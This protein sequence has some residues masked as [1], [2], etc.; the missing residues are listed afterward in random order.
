MTRHETKR[1]K[2]DEAKREETK[3]KQTNKANKN[4]QK[5]RKT[6]QKTKTNKKDQNETK[7]NKRTLRRDDNQRNKTRQDKDEDEEKDGLQRS[8]PQLR[9]SPR[10][11]I[12]ANPSSHRLYQ[13]RRQFAGCFGMAGFHQNASS[14]VFVLS[15]VQTE[16]YSVKLAPV[17]LLSPDWLLFPQP[18]QL[19]PLAAKLGEYGLRM[20][21]RTAL[22]REYQRHVI[23]TP[24]CT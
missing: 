15:C 20:T 2:Q 1:T 21:L 5:Q 9:R 4:K 3:Q 22:C 7:H 18:S 17:G 19:H 24:L 13:F 11:H 16:Q 14:S 8:A 23:D 10:R 6:K 12:I